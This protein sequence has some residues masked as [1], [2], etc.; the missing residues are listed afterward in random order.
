MTSLQMVARRSCSPSMSATAQLLPQHSPSGKLT[1][2]A[3][4]SRLFVGS[5]THIKTSDGDNLPAKIS[6]GEWLMVDLELIHAGF[7][8]F[9]ADVH[10]ESDVI[11]AFCELCETELFLFRRTGMQTVLE[12]KLPSSTQYFG[13]SFEPHTFRY[14]AIFV[15]SGSI[16]LNSIGFRKMRF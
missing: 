11:V 3:T 6:A 9:S 5:A 8:R 4:T 2:P 7:L 12:Y 1:T 13:E 15:K 14:V 16:T 10:E